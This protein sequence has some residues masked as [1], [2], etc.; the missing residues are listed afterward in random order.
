MFG[1]PK[2][3]KIRVGTRLNTHSLHLKDCH[4]TPLPPGY[5]DLSKNGPRYRQVEMH[6]GIPDRD[7]DSLPRNPLRVGYFEPGFQQC[8][9]TK[10][11]KMLE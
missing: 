11:S 6:S 2:P 8:L 1:H 9:R 4:C 7:R 10:Q 3:M 5:P